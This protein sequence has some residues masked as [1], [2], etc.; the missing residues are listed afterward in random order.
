MIS[1]EIAEI[2]GI[3][4]NWISQFT[5]EVKY[6]SLKC[7]RLLLSVNFPYILGKTKD[8]IGLFRTAISGGMAGVTLWT[9]I[10]PADVIKSRQ[11]VSTLS[12]VTQM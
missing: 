7:K 9:V 8:E 10:F 11:Q 6:D 12:T 4:V 1:R 5:T 3:G 2:T